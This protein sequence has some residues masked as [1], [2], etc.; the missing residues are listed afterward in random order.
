VTR[1]FAPNIPREPAFRQ[2][3]QPHQQGFGGAIG[4]MNAGLQ[5]FQFQG[6][7]GMADQRI[8]RFAGKALAPSVAPEKESDFAALVQEIQAA[9]IDAA[10]GVVVRPNGPIE[11]VP[12]LH[13]RKLARDNLDGGSGPRDGGPVPESGRFA[14]AQYGKE[15]VRVVLA[16]RTQA[17]PSGFQN[18]GAIMTVLCARRKGFQKTMRRPAAFAP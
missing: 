15:G 16:K 12:V 14:V 7:E 1:A 6:P 9:E 13:G 17:Q 4:G 18:H 3:P 2:K 8:R 10:D 11:K 5:P